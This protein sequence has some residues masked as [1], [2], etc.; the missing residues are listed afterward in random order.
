MSDFLATENTSRMLCYTANQVDFLPKVFVFSQVRNFDI[1]L[2]SK[3][4][5]NLPL[6][7]ERGLRLCIFFNEFPGFMD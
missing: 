5:G 6:A 1:F 3:S 4:Q 2:L 7:K